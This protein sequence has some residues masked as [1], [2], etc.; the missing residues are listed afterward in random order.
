MHLECGCSTILLSGQPP[1]ILH[2]MEIWTLLLP[3]QDINRDVLK[4]FLWS[5]SFM[6]PLLPDLPSFDYIYFNLY[7]LGVVTG[8]LLSAV[9]NLLP[10]L[11]LGF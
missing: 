4:S 3:L 7:P 8:L 6:Q 9:P 5:F 1:Q 2:W 10:T 11:S